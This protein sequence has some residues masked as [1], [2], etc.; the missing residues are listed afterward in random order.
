MDNERARDEGIDHGAAV[1]DL[2][3]RYHG[4]LLRYFARRG[5]DPESAHDLV[6]EVF[7]RL[8]RHGALDGVANPQG[9]LFAAAGNIAMDYFRRR[10][11]RREYLQTAQGEA[12]ANNDEFTPAR[13]AE[14]REELGAV[15][16]ALNE[17]PTRMRNVFILARLEDMPRSAIAEQLGISKR[18]VEL[19]ITQATAW[20][21]EKLERMR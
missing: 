12:Q 10:S 2:S 9:Y 5:I 16:S 7:A 11:V 13:I 6:Q 4:A 15:V 17:M 19:Q 14:G 3:R 1:E 20:L 21:A 8:V 18:L